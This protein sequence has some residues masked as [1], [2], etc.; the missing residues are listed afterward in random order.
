MAGGTRHVELFGRLDRWSAVVLAGN[1]SYLDQAPVESD[2][3]LKAVRVTRF[4][5]NGPSRVLTWMSYMASAFAQGM[6]GPRPTV[7]WGS[8]PQMGAAIVALLCARIRRAPFVLEI[9]DLWPHILVEAEV[10]PRNGVVHRLITRIEE[11]LYRSAAAIVVLAEGTQREL[12]GRG[13][14]GAKVHFVPNGADVGAF[15][16]TGT[17]ESRRLALGLDDRLV[18]IYAGAHGP[19]N[20]LDLVLDAAERLRETDSEA[21]FLLVGDGVQKPA[22]QRR[23]DAAGLDNVRFHDPVPKDE[24]PELYE[25]SDIGLHCLDDVDLFKYGVSPNKLY[26]YMAARLPVI[27]NAGGD[28]AAMVERAD[29]GVAVEPRSIADGVRL[30]EEASG[31]QR[32]EWAENGHRFMREH[33][34]RDALARQVEDLLDQVADPS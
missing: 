19:A 21:L 16:G 8:S 32:S 17:R 10:I 15:A 6:R 2:G 34:S 3:V 11:Y 13:F 26:D 14:D 33:R 24:I 25:A 4:R 5:G 7:V 30:I 18:V 22:L 9:R 31:A 20:G 1:K 29:S 28:V 12:V 23:A 27:T